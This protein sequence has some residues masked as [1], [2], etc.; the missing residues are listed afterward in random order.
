[1]RKKPFLTDAPFICDAPIQKS[2]CAGYKR[3]VE[4][5][6]VYALSGILRNVTIDRLI[7]LIK[8]PVGINR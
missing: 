5:C 7:C 2:R 1:M 4:A 3:C 6:P 8:L